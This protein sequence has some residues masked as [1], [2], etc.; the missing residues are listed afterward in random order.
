[1]VA[2]ILCLALGLIMT[3][4]SVVLSAMSSSEAKKSNT[5]DA[6]RYSMFSAISSG[7]TIVLLAIAL[8]IYVQED[9]CVNVMSGGRVYPQGYA[10]PGTP[11]SR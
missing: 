10:R 1:M 2:V 11:L 7:A 8:I 9:R 3:F 6:E 4:G 5:K